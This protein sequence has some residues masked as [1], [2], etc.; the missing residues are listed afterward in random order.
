MQRNLV[1]L[2]GLAALGWSAGFAP[3]ASA[4]IVTYNLISGSP[5]D[6]LVTATISGGIFSNTTLDFNGAASWQLNLSS[7]SLT[8]DNGTP[9]LDAFSFG[10]SSAG[11]DT[12]SA[13]GHTLGT[14][15][16]TNIL[17]Q[18]T[19]NPDATLTG[20]NPYGL[21]TSNV[22]DSANYSVTP[23]GGSTKTGSISNTGTPI[24]GSIVTGGTMPLSFAQSDTI[25]LG[26][27]N[28]TEGG[29]S[30]TVS[31][32]GDTNFDGASTVPVPAGLWLLASGLGVLG[33][34]W[35][36]RRPSAGALMPR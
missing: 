26:T 29:V 17:V 25:Q 34:G 2:S 16:L 22:M 9:A 28:F 7:G 33:L 8:L 21:N 20:T 1:I 4:S 30:Y 6:V 32:K 11:P 13:G 19:K 24:T 36:R 23:A 5:S 15:S 18:S 12:I 10:D 3:S 27:I 31:L 14:L 35:R